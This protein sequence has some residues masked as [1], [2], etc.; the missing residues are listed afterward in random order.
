M[1]MPDKPSRSVFVPVLIVGMVLIIGLFVFATL[2]PVKQCKS[3]CVE[4]RKLKLNISPPCELCDGEAKIPL[5]N[6]WRR[7]QWET[8]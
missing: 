6:I 8:P 5:W 7:E 3:F 2:V 4:L 1:T